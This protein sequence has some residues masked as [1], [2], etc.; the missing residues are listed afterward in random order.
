MSSLFPQHAPDIFSSLPRMGPI[1]LLHL[2]LTLLAFSAPFTVASAQDASVSDP[3]N[4]MISEGQPLRDNVLLFPLYGQLA[5]NQVDGLL[6]FLKLWSRQQEVT[7]A[8]NYTACQGSQFCCPD[9]NSCCS[10]E[11]PC[12]SLRS[13]LRRGCG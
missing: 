7:C 5:S 3:P 10:G 4:E 13:G 1:R 8:T 11:F 12:V 2:S 9:G 6:L